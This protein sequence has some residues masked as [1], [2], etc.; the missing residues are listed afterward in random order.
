[1]SL[2]LY[3]SLTVREKIDLPP[4]MGSA[5]GMCNEVTC[6][7]QVAL[8]RSSLFNDVEIRYYQE[9]MQS[10]SRARRKP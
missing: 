4:E 8:S 1:V 2:F 7:D 3:G 10:L 5:H 9:E 6:A